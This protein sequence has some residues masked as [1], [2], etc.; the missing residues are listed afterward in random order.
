MG[1]GWGGSG[2]GLSAGVCLLE[3]I[4]D[5]DGDCIGVEERVVQNNV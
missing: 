4:R 5:G 3:E 2:C 1:G